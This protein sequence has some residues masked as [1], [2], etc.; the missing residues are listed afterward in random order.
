MRDNQLCNLLHE[1]WKESRGLG[2][3][4]RFEYP[5][6]SDVLYDRLSLV[7]SSDCV[8]LWFFPINVGNNH[9]SLL[10]VDNSQSP[11]TVLFFDPLGNSIPRRGVFD[12]LRGRVGGIRVRFLRERVQYDGCHCGVW[13]CWCASRLILFRSSY[14]DWNKF[15]L[16]GYEVGVNTS[17]PQIMQKNTTFIAKV[18]SVYAE[19]LFHAEQRG[20][21]LIAS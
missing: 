19:R 3:A 15:S 17:D 12:S 8:G 13:V 2:L 18:R 9:W 16:R 1:V 10:L 20:Q 4:I 6:R 7:P 11:W 21:L 14:R 5:I